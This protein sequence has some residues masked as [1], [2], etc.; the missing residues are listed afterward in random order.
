MQGTSMAT[1]HVT[2][3][4]ALLLSAKPPLTAAQIKNYFISTARTDTFTSAVWNSSWGFGK[5][6]IFKAMSTVTGVERLSVEL[7][8][9]YT[10]NQNYPNPFNPTT[11]I[12]YSIPMKGLVKL[13]IFDMLGRMVASLV[14]EVQNAGV[15]HAT[16]TGKTGNSI[17]VSSGVYFYRLQSG[18][19]S[20]TERMLLLK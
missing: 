14:E 5:M 18:A 2:G 17:P 7:P 11:N 20:K 12:E 4:V 15:Y 13:Q 6:D 1:P 9:S 19:F 8:T 16:W 3:G 10:L